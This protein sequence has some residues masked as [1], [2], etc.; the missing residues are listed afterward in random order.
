MQSRIFK[1]NLDCIIFSTSSLSLNV[2]HKSSVTVAELR[3]YI[4][5]MKN[6]KKSIVKGGKNACTCSR[7]RI[8][9]S[10]SAQ[11][12]R[13]PVQTSSAKQA[14]GANTQPDGTLFFLIFTYLKGRS[15]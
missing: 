1:V 2:A 4:T 15:H 3:D 8:G 7:I 13:T 14:T 10:Y 11:M 12:I 9:A 6:F 5:R